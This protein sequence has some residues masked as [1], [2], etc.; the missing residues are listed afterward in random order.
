MERGV[1]TGYV[2]NGISAPYFVKS[3]LI[4]SVNIYIFKFYLSLV[5]LI[6][7]IFIIRDHI[8]FFFLFLFLGGLSIFS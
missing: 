3:S 1:A 5:F 6:L 2:L 7:S 4:F 8:V